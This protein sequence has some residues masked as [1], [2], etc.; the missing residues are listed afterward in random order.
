MFIILCELIVGTTDTSLDYVLLKE[1][2]IDI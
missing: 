1:D 2:R